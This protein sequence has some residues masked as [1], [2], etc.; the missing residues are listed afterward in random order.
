MSNIY[1]IPKSFP[2]EFCN[3]KIPVNQLS[4]ELFDRYICMACKHEQ[5]KEYYSKYFGMIKDLKDD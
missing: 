2:C 4:D 5:S 3:S 1:L